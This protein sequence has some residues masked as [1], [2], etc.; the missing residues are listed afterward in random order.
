MVHDIRK[1]T[2]RD[3][4]AAEKVRIVLER[5]RGEDRIVELCGC[6][7]FNPNVYCRW[8]KEFLEAG[9]KCLP[10]DTALEATSEAYE[11]IQSG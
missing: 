10:G 4:S 6:E 11:I 3:Y 1:V 7:G 2:R 8:S 5:L 9:K